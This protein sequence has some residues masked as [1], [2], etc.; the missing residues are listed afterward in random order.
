[1]AFTADYF[2]KLGFMLG[3][4]FCFQFRKAILCDEKIKLEWMII[5][6]T[7]QAKLDGDLI[8]LL[9]RILNSH[10]ITAVAKGLVL[11]KS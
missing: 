5:K 8:D 7:S 6:I 3:L 1:M 2:S 9:G 11:L 10:G 4:E